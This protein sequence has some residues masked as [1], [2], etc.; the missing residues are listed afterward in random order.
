MNTDDFIAQIEADEREDALETSGVA[1]PVNY[2]RSRSINPQ[3]VYYHIRT[4]HLVVEFC[5]CGRKVISVEEA[6]K[7]FR[8][9]KT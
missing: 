4:G 5:A 2:A 8:K 3:N 7:I 6:D 1:T 9:G